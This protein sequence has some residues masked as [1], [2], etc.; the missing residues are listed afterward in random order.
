MRRSDPVRTLAEVEEL[1]AQPPVEGSFTA[2]ELKGL[3][4]PVRRHLAAAIA[5]GTPLATSVRLRMRGS[6]RIGRWLPFRAREVLAPHHGFAWAARVAGLIAGSDRYAQGSGGMDWRL[7]GLVGL[8]RAEGADISRSS[9]ERAAGEALWVP[10]A[11]L[12]R[13]DVEWSA[14]DD[15]HLAARYDVDG[16][17]VLMRFALASPGGRIVS[18]GLDRWGD[19]DRSGTWAVHPFGGEVTGYATFDGVTIPAAG[20]VGWFY[21][22]DRWPEGEFFRYRITDLRLVGSS[23]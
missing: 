15:R 7:G 11:L 18:F 23:P 2:A 8:A 12:P 21:G 13:F 1:L 19:P 22:T 4:E 14:T 5:P 16:R 3:P 17:P 10:T 20:R 6:I 9:A